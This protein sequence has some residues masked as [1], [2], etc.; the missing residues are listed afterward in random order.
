M[1]FHG[2]QWLEW[3]MRP[4]VAA[5]ALLFALPA[6]AGELVTGPALVVD[7]DTLVIARERIRLRN[8]NAPEL[9]RPGGME[10]MDA[11]RALVE[12]KS[13]VCEGKARD[14]YGRL[15]ALCSV[16][17]VDLGKELKR[18]IRE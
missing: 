10:A 16:D 8:F 9:D 17:G 2:K 4:W 3:P 12:S 6:Q 5:L 7:G 1:P 11:L 14:R 18:Q 13:V 15:V